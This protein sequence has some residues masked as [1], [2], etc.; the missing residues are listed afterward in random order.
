MSP[1]PIDD[2]FDS[3]T[4]AF[5]KWLLQRPGTRVSPKIQI[6]DFRDGNAGRGI[7]KGLGQFERDGLTIH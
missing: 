7:G 5:M 3:K 4:A 6:A 1:R 2:E